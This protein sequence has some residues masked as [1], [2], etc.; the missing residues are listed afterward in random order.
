M[1]DFIK[2]LAD[3]RHEGTYLPFYPERVKGYSEAEVDLIASWYNLNI[4]GQF[5]QFLLQMG[6]CSGGLLWG[7]NFPMYD[8]RY[9]LERFK[10]GQQYLMED[11]DYLYLDGIDAVENKLFFLF[12]QNEQMRR[13]YVVTAHQDNYILAYYND[14]TRLVERSP[15]DLLGVLKDYVFYET[16]SCRFSDVGFPEALVDECITGR[17]L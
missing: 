15:L 3:S 12:H 10:C 17:L 4:Y 6:R 16:K 13:F 2:E 8:S 11:E 1:I 9:N 7:D 5:R 14:S